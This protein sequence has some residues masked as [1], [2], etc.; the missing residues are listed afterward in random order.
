MHGR[1]CGGSVD[2]GSCSCM[3]FQEGYGTYSWTVSNAD[4]EEGAK[5]T[6]KFAGVYK[7]GKKEGLGKMLYPNGDKYHGMWVNNQ[8]HV[9][10]SLHYKNLP[11]L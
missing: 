2:C 5:H 3:V 7:D 1:M 10:R 8:K 4:E 6:A 11:K 9:S